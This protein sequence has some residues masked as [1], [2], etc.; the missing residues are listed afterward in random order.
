MTDAYV[1]TTILADI[2]LKPK[3]S[4]RQKAID[5]LAR[6]DRTMLPV[7]SIKEWKA[8]ALD[9]FAYLHD[10]LVETKSVAKT[11]RAVAAL[12]RTNRKDTSVEALAAAVSIKQPRT[13][14]G[15]VDIDSVLADR[16][17]LNLMQLIIRSWGRRRTITTEVVDELPCYVESAPRVGK[18]GYFDLRPT[19]CDPDQECCLG[20]LLKSQPARLEALREAISKTSN[21]NEDI[22]RRQALKLLLKRPKEKVDRET[23]R[24]LGDAI[25]AFFCPEGAVVLTTNLRDHKPLAES[26]GR[27][28]EKPG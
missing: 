13:F 17:R 20:P 25:F 19:K 15:A 12:P 23:C 27:S 22:K 6:Y 18:D 26:V 10:K 3:S 5:A 21:R 11:W 1:E 9:Y 8:G 16:Y 2:L 14:A 28:A 24:H 4:K 7:Y